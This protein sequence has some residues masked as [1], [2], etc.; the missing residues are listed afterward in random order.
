MAND[1]CSALV[2]NR[3][4]YISGLFISVLFGRQCAHQINKNALLQKTVFPKIKNL[5][6]DPS[7]GT[8]RKPTSV[9]F[10]N[11]LV[12]P[13]RV[14]EMGGRTNAPKMNVYICHIF[15]RI[16]SEFSQNIPGI[17]QQKIWVAQTWRIF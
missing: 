17:F 6:P 10:E 2:S 8:T 15:L 11:T 12:S 9:F 14:H 13:M 5:P 3:A 7:D 4:W 16:L 1:R